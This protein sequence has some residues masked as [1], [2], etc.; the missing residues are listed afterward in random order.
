MVS[1]NLSEGHWELH[2]EQPI[3]ANVTNCQ[4]GEAEV[5][6][7]YVTTWKRVF[8]Q[9]DIRA[10]TCTKSPCS[11]LCVYCV[12][13][14]NVS[15]FAWLGEESCPQSTAQ[16]DCWH[17]AKESL[18]FKTEWGRG[19]Q[20]RVKRKTRLVGSGWRMTCCLTQKQT[21]EE[22]PSEGEKRRSEGGP[23]TKPYLSLF[24]LLTLL[25]SFSCCC[26]WREE[27]DK[28]KTMNPDTGKKNNYLYS[29]GFRVVVTYSMLNAYVY[30]PAHT[31]YLPS[32]FLSPIHTIL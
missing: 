26:C 24:L 28:D 14:Y 29:Y 10:H 1:A 5:R 20:N 6:L 32:L 27:T 17:V 23:I 8:F 30:L 15:V 16:W 19:E 13:A 11:V 22:S 31:H 2:A 3:T 12:H 4:G 18:P 7:Q 9:S 21:G 25:S